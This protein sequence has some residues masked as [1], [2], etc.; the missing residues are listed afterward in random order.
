MAILGKF[1]KQ[2]ADRLDYDIDYRDWLTDRNDTLASATVTAEAGLTVSDFV[3]VEG[4]VK[5]YLQGGTDGTTYKVTCTAT[6]TGGRIKQAEI[7]V[8]VKEY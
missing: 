7:S 5:I 1:I 6:T 8:A 3:L 4:V 2:P